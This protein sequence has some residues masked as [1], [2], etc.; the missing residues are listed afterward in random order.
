MI[1]N[2]HNFAQGVEE[3]GGLANITN[4]ASTIASAGGAEVF[5]DNLSNVQHLTT[6]TG[7]PEQL[8]AALTGVFAFWLL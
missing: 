4:V 8:A 5:N 1:T 2:L 6:A 3:A 7:G